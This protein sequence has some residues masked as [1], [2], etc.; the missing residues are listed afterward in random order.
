MLTGN[1]LSAA[2]NSVGLKAAFCVMSWS[3]KFESLYGT[4]HFKKTSTAVK[5]S[6]N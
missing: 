6:Q 5:F 2:V 1:K 3:V 4:K